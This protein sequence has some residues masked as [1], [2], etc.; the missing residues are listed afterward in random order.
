MRK[1]ESWTVRAVGVSFLED[2]RQ[3]KPL[4][5]F[6]RAELKRIAQRKNIEALAAAGYE[7]VAKRAAM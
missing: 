3:E 6:T 2:Q 1:E 5:D 7:P 4:E